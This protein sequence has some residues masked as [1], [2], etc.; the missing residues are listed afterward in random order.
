MRRGLDLF[1]RPCYNGATMKIA[2]PKD[3]GR[4]LRTYRK[5]HG[6]TLTELSRRLGLAPSNI[7]RRERGQ[8][9]MSEAAF[10]RA[11]ATIAEIAEERDRDA[12]L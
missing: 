1:A 11:L 5:A 10:L 6:V 8:A 4:L 9:P 3:R 7:S 2:E 12:W